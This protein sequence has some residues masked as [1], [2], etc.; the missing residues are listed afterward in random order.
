MA[1]TIRSDSKMSPKRQQNYAITPARWGH[2]QSGV[3]MESMITKVFIMR[4]SN[5]VQKQR[6]RRCSQDPI[7]LRQSLAYR[8]LSEQDVQGN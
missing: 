7:A 3:G 1:F 4:K 2:L 8:N 5:I 6:S